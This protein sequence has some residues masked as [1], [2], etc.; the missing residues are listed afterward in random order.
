MVRRVVTGEVGGKGAIMSDAAAPTYD[1]GN[2]AQLHEVWCAPH[3]DGS[4]PPGEDWSLNPPA[5]GS[6][7]RVAEFPPASVGEE[8]Y[9]HRTPTIDFGVVLE[10]ELTLVLDTG[11]TVLRPGDTFVQRQANHG[12]INRGSAFVRMAVVLI[13]GE[14]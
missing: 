14:Q 7:F 9:M 12:W 5:S 6:V 2:G 3:R 4:Y 10:G 13:D 1:M 8:P 11:E